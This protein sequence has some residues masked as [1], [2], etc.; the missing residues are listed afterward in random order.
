[1]S[2][3]AP[4]PSNRKILKNNSRTVH[5]ERGDFYMLARAVSDSILYSASFKPEEMKAEQMRSTLEPL[6]TRLKKYAELSFQRE[7]DTILMFGVTV[8]KVDIISGIIE[9]SFIHNVARVNT[10]Y[11]ITFNNYL[12]PY[13]EKWSDLLRE[14]GAKGVENQY[15]LV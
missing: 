12:A 8:E 2:N 13:S 14:H 6:Y 7:F 4:L 1:M 10:K 9:L 3:H 15:Q 11:K 5:L